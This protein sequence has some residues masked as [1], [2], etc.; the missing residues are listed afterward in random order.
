MIKR[1]CELGTLNFHRPM[2]YKND[3]PGVD[4][5]KDY[6]DTFMSITSNT[7]WQSCIDACVHCAQACEFCATCDLSESDVKVVLSCAQINR[8][9]R[10]VLD[11]RVTP[12][13]GRSV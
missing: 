1:L 9:C 4:N 2:F 13:H 6:P 10:S 12:V 7:K 8:V 11:M 5:R 3:L